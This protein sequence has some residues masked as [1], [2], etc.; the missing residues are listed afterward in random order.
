MRLALAPI[1]DRAA[2]PRGAQLLADDSPRRRSS[3]LPAA[4]RPAGLRRPRVDRRE[5]LGWPWLLDGVHVLA[6]GV[7]AG[8]LVLLAVA[9]GAG[10]CAARPGAAP[11][12]PAA[13]RCSRFTRLAVG[14]VAVLAVT[15]TIAALRELDAVDE[16]VDTRYGQVLALKVLVVAGRPGRCA[17]QPPRRARASCATCAA[18]RRSWRVVI[19]LTAV[20]TGLA[21]GQRRGGLGRAR[22]RSSG[23]SE[24]HTLT[25]DIAPAAR[26]PPPN[27]V[28]VVVTNPVGQP[29]FD[30]RRRAARPW[31]SRPPGITDLEVP[32]EAAHRGP[33]DGHDHLPA[34]RRLGGRADRAPRDVRRGDRERDRAGVPAEAPRP[35]RRARPA[36]GAAGGRVR[37]R[38]GDHG[39]RLPLAGDGRA[40][41]RGRA[42]RGRRRPPGGDAHR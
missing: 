42:R 10:L 31:G 29:A 33:L 20:L 41:G 17:R 11:A 1:A 37:A 8:G 21:P 3:R 4:G 36:A 18:R 30:V 26:R 32:L 27:E 34:A 35:R 5:R 24:P 40:R 2:D 16:L 22:S 23:P 28:H 9:L 39:R 6:A 38:R 25:F 12:L 14:A 13:A 15:G 19:V 7:W